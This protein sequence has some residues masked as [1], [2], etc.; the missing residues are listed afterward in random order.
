MSQNFLDILRIC[1]RG[2]TVE[3]LNDNMAELTKAVMEAN[4]TGSLTLKISMKPDGN[5]S[6]ELDSVVTLKKP[7][8]KRGK[9]IMFVSPDGA[10]V[11]NDPR[12]TDLPLRAVPVVAPIP[13]PL[14]LSSSKVATQ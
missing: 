11:R 8:I 6:V 13:V 5:N 4:G 12:Q 2:N 3:Q 7:N 1:Q 9:T 14:P 10:L